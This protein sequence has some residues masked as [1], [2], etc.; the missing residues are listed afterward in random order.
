VKR[1]WLRLACGAAASLTVLFLSERARPVAPT[2][3]AGDALHADMI[4]A[5]HAQASDEL[6]RLL[7][8]LP[9][10][11]TARLSGIYL[12]FDAHTAEPTAMAAC[13]DD[14]DY[15]VVMSDLLLGMIDYVAK[16]KAS[17][18]VF[19]TRKLD[20][21]AAWL[22]RPESKGGRLVTPPA[23]SIDP[24]QAQSPAKADLER[25]RLRE[26]LSGVIAHELMHLVFG[27]IT[28][29][30]PTVAH[31]RGDDEWTREEREHALSVALK[32][33]TT[34]RVL[35]ADGAGTLLSLQASRTEEGIVALLLTF[36]RIERSGLDAA[37]AGPSGQPS[38]TDAPN[39]AASSYLRLHPGSD[40][41]AQ[42][43]RAAANQWRRLQ[44]GG[45]R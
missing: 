45:A 27:D 25:A 4:S 15:V 7:A 12:A 28:C 18:E 37:S 8:K 29:P 21:Y 42:V 36:D 33:Y 20:E 11:Q 30:S 9:K 22:S 14:G 38:A 40:L 6:R 1:V 32:V 44:A 10:A 13:D 2:K 41:R 5:L 39:R 34:P 16:A 26:A 17:D 43:V 19:A 35:A 3:V 31:E 23:D 24:P